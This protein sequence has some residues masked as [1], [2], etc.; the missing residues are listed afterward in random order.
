MTRNR[1][2]E[3]RAGGPVLTAEDWKR[4]EAFAPKPSQMVL[5]VAMALNWLWKK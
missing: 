2:S 3:L 1:L 4:L 5:R